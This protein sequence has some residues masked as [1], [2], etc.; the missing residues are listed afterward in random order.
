MCQEL[1]LLEKCEEEEPKP[2]RLTDP[3]RLLEEDADDG[4]EV[5][6]VVVGVLDLPNHD[7]LLP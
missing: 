5:G 4:D 3:T 7:P 1:E 2:P 6:E